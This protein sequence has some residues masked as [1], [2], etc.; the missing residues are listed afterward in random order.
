MIGPCAKWFNQ[1]TE[2]CKYGWVQMKYPGCC[3]AEKCECNCLYL[4]N[5]KKFGRKALEHGKK[6][7]DFDNTKCTNNITS[8]EEGDEW[9]VKHCL[10]D[11]LNQTKNSQGNFCF[12]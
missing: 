1:A 3:S 12:N 8:K 10:E 5:S 4:C 6:L 11:R 7:N 2:K 9:R